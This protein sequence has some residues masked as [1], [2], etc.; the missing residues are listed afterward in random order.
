LAE[1]TLDLPGDKKLLLS[2]DDK[3]SIDVRRVL[4]G[5]LKETINDIKK[6]LCE[7]DDQEGWFYF[8]LCDLYPHLD[9][10]TEYHNSLDAI[11]SLYEVTRKTSLIWFHEDEEGN[12]VYDG[13]APLI[14]EISWFD[15]NWLIQYYVPITVCKYLKDN[16]VALWVLASLEKKKFPKIL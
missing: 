1:Y 8:H 4:A 15:E 2:I 11:T 12:K 9:S 14:G 5:I 3:L 6:S 7:S 10:T 13:W 16:S